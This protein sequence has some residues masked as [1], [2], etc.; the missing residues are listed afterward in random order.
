MQY[1]KHSVDLSIPIMMEKKGKTEVL[2]L[3]ICIN[4]LV[5]ALGWP[6]SRKLEKLTLLEIYRELWG[7]SK[8]LS[9]LDVCCVSVYAQCLWSI[10]SW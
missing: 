3:A 9:L 8:S 7:T 10:L 5:Q 1:L 4:I 6:F 2:A